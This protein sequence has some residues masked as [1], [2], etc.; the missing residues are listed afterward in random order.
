MSMHWITQDW[1]LKMRIMGMINFPQRHTAA[2]IS[3]KLMDLRLDFGVYPRSRDG[4]PPQSLQAMRRHK[5][6]YFKEEPDLDKPVLTN[7]CG[8]DVSVGAERDRL[9]DWNRC[10]CHCLN[11]AVQAALKEEVVHECLAPLMA[12]AARFSKSRSLWNKFKK[13]QMGILDWEEECSDDEGEADFDRDEDLEVGGE[14]EPCLKRVFQLI[15]PMLTH[16]NS[17][18]YLMKRALALK[19]ALVQFVD[20]H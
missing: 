13:T 1:R 9:W 4:R 10:A 7:D 6:F 12:L 14:G 16:W 19:D 3:D 15:K 18:Y 2:N 17:T 8:S 5:V 20:C 11:I